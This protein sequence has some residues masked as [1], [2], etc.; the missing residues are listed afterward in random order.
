M[1]RISYNAF[2]GLMEDKRT[3]PTPE[4]AFR[5]VLIEVADIYNLTS[6]Q[7]KLK[8][9][10]HKICEARQVCMYLLR[11]KGLHY[12]TIGALFGMDHT[13]AIHSMKKVEDA[14][15]AYPTFKDMVTGLLHKLNYA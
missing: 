8:T 4:M 1:T 2:P 5:L 15:D 13:T 10:Q 12:K 11:K 14:A 6:A 7:I 3:R 9:R